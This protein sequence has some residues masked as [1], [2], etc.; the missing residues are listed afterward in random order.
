MTAVVQASVRVLHGFV[1]RDG[2]L[3]LWG[4][5]S[6]RSAFALPASS[7][8]PGDA[9]PPATLILPSTSAGPLPSPQLGLPPRRG[10]PKLRAWEVPAVTVPFLDEDVADAWDGR[11]GASVRWMV[12]LCSFAA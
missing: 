2:S 1:G 7:L 3:A 6:D 5:S 11:L 10:T 9:R 4:E 8:P 12:E